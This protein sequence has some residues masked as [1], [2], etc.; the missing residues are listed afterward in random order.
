MRTQKNKTIQQLF[1]VRTI[2]LSRH[3][4]ILISSQSQQG[5]GRLFL[6]YLKAETGIRGTLS[7]FQL[8]QNHYL[9][10]LRRP[11]SHCLC[12][13]RERMSAFWRHNFVPLPHTLLEAF[14]S[15]GQKT[16]RILY[17]SAPARSKQ[18]LINNNGHFMYVVSYMYDSVMVLYHQNN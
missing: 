5:P 10:G 12:Q 1:V 13:N 3:R 15:S 11:R 16:L 8:C 18:S 9:G 6:P 17:C 14:A 4:H 7:I 2:E